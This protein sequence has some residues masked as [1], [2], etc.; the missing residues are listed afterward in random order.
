M[1]A[2]VAL[3][4]RYCRHGSARLRAFAHDQ[5]EPAARPWLGD[6][7]TGLRRAVLLC[8]VVLWPSMLSQFVLCLPCKILDS[9]LMAGSCNGYE[10]CIGLRNAS[11]VH[12]SRIERTS[13]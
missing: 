1:I 10:P 13:Y 6:G 2:L 12:G 11:D 5:C 4:Q 3:G 8:A 9:R 7:R